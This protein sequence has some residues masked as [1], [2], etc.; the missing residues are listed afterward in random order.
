MY[1]TRREPFT[2]YLVSIDLDPNFVTPYPREH[3]SGAGDRP[4]LRGT[5]YITPSISPYKWCRN[6]S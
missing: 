5:C 3:A 1:I 2:L 4:V 6:V